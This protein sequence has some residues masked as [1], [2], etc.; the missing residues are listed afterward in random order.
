MATLEPIAARQHAGLGI[1]YRVAAM[2]CMACL[3]AL[4]KWT[5]HRGVPVFEIVFFRNAFAFVPLGL[6]IWRTTG[7]LGA[8][9]R[10]A[11]GPPAPAR[12][13]AWSAWSAASRPCSTCR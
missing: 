9:D 13:S 1:A 3:S 12:R 10:A 2:A 6:Y 4:V 7:G 5:G 11:A 8:E